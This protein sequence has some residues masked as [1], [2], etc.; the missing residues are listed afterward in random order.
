MKKKNVRE[1]QMVST[2][3]LRLCAEK[4]LVYPA[5]GEDTTAPLLSQEGCTPQKS[6]ILPIFL[7]FDSVAILIPQNSCYRAGSKCSALK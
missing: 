4:K 2:I 5:P 6:H 1:S 7:R 3:S